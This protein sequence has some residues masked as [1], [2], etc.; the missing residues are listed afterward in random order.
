[1][2]VHRYF[3]DTILAGIIHELAGRRS[4]PLRSRPIELY[5]EEDGKFI[6]LPRAYRETQSAANTKQVGAPVYSYVRSLR[7]SLLRPDNVL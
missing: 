1:M 6:Y 4:K 5:L 3:W 2:L 7:G